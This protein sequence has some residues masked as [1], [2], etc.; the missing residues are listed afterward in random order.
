MRSSYLSYLHGVQENQQGTACCRP[1]NV[2]VLVSL[3]ILMELMMLMVDGSSVWNDV[4]PSK[5]H[6]FGV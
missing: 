4:V 2:F 6:I 5:N 3:V 1:G